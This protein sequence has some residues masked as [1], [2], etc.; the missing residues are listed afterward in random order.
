MFHVC[1]RLF[2]SLSDIY[3]V[4]SWIECDWMNELLIINEDIHHIE[5]DHVIIFFEILD[6]ISDIRTTKQIGNQSKDFSEI[7]IDNSFLL[8][9]A[10][11]N[12]WYSIGWAFLRPSD[13]QSYSNLNQKCSLQLYYYQRQR[14]KGN[15]LVEWKTAKKL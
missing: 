2:I 6:I 14:T 7:L 1:F 12:G 10:D 9:V 13:C 4:R 5:K 8:F 15:I 11:S 3:H